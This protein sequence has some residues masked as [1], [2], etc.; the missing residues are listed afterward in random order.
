MRSG[1]FTG[2]PNWPISWVVRGLGGDIQL[3]ARSA[4]LQ[5]ALAIA[6]IYNHFI[7]HTLITFEEV[8]ISERDVKVRLEQVAELGLPWLV[9]EDVNADGELQVL[10]YA[11]AGKFR[12]RASYRFTVE[13]AIYLAP[14]AAG[15]G[16][17]GTLYRRLLDEL[18]SKQLHR[19]VAL[20][21]RARV[22]HR[23]GRPASRSRAAPPPT[24]MKLDAF[25]P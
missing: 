15:Q 9:W 22:Q 14:Q 13:T 6:E 16:I 21:H 10:G 12:E 8:V 25:E 17:G 19:A 3:A 1:M 23:A 4:S 11:Y 5:D 7:E 24:E 18:R 2:L 20:D